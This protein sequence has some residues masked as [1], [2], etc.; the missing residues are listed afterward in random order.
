[1]RMQADLPHHSA[2]KARTVADIDVRMRW[3]GALRRLFLRIQ[4][5]ERSPIHPSRTPPPFYI[6][7]LLSVLAIA[8]VYA[9]ALTGYLFALH[10]TFSTAAEDLGIIDQTLWNTVHGHFMLQTICNPIGDQNCLGV[11][12]RFAIHFE[13]VLALLAPLYLLV[14]GVKTLMVLQVFAVVSGVVPAYLLAARRL[15]H[16]GWGVAFSLLYLLHPSLQAVTLSV[17]HPESLAAP[18]LL[19]VFYCL[20]LRR[21]RTV[22][23]L[24]IVV[25][26]CKETLTLDVCMLGIY[27]ALIHRRRA[28]GIL[29]IVMSLG[30]LVLAL[31][32]MHRASPLGYSPV[33]PRLSGLYQQP[34]Q[35]ITNLILD[36]QRRA[37]PA[38]LLAPMGF[39]PLLS[40]WT[41]MIA[42]P[43][44]LINIFSSDS[45][46]S[47]GGYQYNADIVPVLVVAS[48][49]G[50]A[51]VLPIARRWWRALASAMRSAQFSRAFPSSSSASWFHMRN[52]A[53]VGA[54]ALATVLPLPSFSAQTGVSEVWTAFFKPQ[55]A[56]PAITAHDK[57]GAQL[58]RLIPANSSVS[59]QSMLVPH[60]SERYHVFQFP[61][62]ESNS[63]Y[64][65]LDVSRGSFYPYSTSADYLDA[66]T[67]LLHSC[68]VEVVAAQDG[69]LMFHRIAAQQPAGALCQ[70][71]LPQSFY[72]FAYASPSPG[73]HQISATFAHSLQ[74]AG[75]TLNTT[76]IRTGQTPL[77]VTTY[78]KVEAPPPPV[79]IIVT[80]SRNGETL[81]E[82]PDL[83]TQHWLPPSQWQPGQM[84]R[85]QTWPIYL[86][87]LERGNLTIGVRVSY[88]IPEAEAAPLVAAD[89]TINATGPAP[90]QH[91]APPTLSG[92]GFTV[93]FASITAH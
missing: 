37:Y 68:T 21:F 31:T 20:S 16:V 6:A 38:R 53:V 10:D 35:T 69:Y 59:A 48:I 66:T 19:W 86:G 9:L 78:W 25:L 18:I 90:S 17:F 89:A 84:V 39:L 82:A 29:L 49:D 62:G 56:W 79:T 93:Q 36:P 58:L 33:A 72:S 63:E 67:Q 34:L 5:I 3:R 30:T 87:E 81:L 61:S 73:T 27:V 40:P 14:P 23:V 41:L 11:V 50:L 44:F 26:L 24:C 60:L 43:S 1:M 2:R 42:L 4:W 28:L 46:M 91:T 32:L 76:H 80:I 22:L 85:M 8:L 47:T 54:V 77:I 88:G 57:L 45:L 64:I 12:S 15:R 70:H 52:A 55:S 75:Y 65:A 51:W 13:P 71:P 83:L 92:D 74:F 7:G